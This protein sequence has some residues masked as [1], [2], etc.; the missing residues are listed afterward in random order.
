MCRALPE[1]FL[2]GVGETLSKTQSKPEEQ[3]IEK[4]LTGDYSKNYQCEG[5]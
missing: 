2:E 3:S 5:T 4:V 1:N